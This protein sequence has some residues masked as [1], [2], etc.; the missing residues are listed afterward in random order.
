MHTAKG[1]Q[2]RS[3]IQWTQEGEKNTKY[4]LGLEKAKG[5]ANTIEELKVGEKTLNK[6]L[7][8][9]S[10]IKSYYKDLYTKDTT[11]TNTKEKMNNFLSGIEH[12]I[13]TDEDKNNC[14][15]DITIEELG[16]ALSKLNND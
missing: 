4:F 3:K 13:L 10:G 9:L 1:A 2:I 14:D 5:N 6:P 15:T 16:Q 11:I 7:E 12:P 8:I